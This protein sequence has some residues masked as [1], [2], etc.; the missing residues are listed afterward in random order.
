MTKTGPGSVSRLI[1]EHI[2]GAD[3]GVRGSIIAGIPGARI[4]N[5]VIRDMNLA[6]TGGG[7][8]NPGAVIP[9]DVAD[10]P[11]SNMFGESS[12]AF[13]FWLRH[14]EG[15]SFEDVKITPERPDA[16]PEFNAGDDA[17][18]VQLNGTAIS[19]TAN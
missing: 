16:R 5:V 1:F 8:S 4:Q 17:I 9:E 18:G 2:T 14:A 11:D 7:K 13:G 3:N 19:Q 12:P 10:Y 6:M 15:I